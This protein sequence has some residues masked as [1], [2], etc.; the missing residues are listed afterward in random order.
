MDFI[1]KHKVLFIVIGVVLAI[2]IVMCCIRAV[3]LSKKANEPAPEVPQT[4]PE[5]PI[6]EEEEQETEQSDYQSSLSIKAKEEESKKEEAEKRLAE[7][8]AEEERKKQEEEAKKAAEAA[9]PTYGD[10]V[11]IWSSDGV[12]EIMEDGRSIK[13]YLAEVSLADFGSKWGSALNNEDKLTEDF[14]MVGVDQNPD[15][16]VKGVQ[17]QSFG[18]L[19]DNLNGLPKNGAI[20]FTDLNVVGSL[21]S[22]HVA[23]LCCYNW[24]SVWG[25]KETMMVFED[26]SGTL[27]PAD[28]KPGD[29][30]SAIAYIHNIKVEKVNG[31][32]VICVQYNTFK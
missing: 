23:L 20:K 9:E 8:R 18:W 31:Q 11:K 13:Q 22:D 17:N 1:K 16:Y 7:K 19:I 29:I 25:L 15:D 2:F 27:K 32:T 6:E 30:F 4:V 3:N 10:D 28:F 24:Y 12:P 5:T 14:Y 21:A 26:I